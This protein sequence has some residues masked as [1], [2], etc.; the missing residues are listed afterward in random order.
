MKKE[1]SSNKMSTLEVEV[2]EKVEEQSMGKAACKSISVSVRK[3]WVCMGA[4]VDAHFDRLVELR[5]Y[6]QRRF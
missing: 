2:N 5:V 4:K 6:D 3:V 1:F